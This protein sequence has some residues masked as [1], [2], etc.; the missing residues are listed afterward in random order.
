MVIERLII[1]PTPPGSNGEIE[2][3]NVFRRSIPSSLGTPISTSAGTYNFEFKYAM[4]PVWNDTAVFTMVFVQKD[5]DKTIA[6]AFRHG[7]TMVGITPNLNEIPSGYSL[8]QNYPN[9]FNP[10]T[11]VK[12]NLPEDEF[13]MLKLYDIL[14]NEVRTLVEGNHKAGVYDIT[15]DGSGLSS[16]IY[17]YRL[18][19]G[20]FT[21]TKKMTLLK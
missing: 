17:F 19:A 9:P 1:Y 6:N 21:N 4:H 11:N 15:V 5:N 3:Q 18:S 12:F 8:E 20:K 7:M 14:G 10:A 13:V 16:G 2:F